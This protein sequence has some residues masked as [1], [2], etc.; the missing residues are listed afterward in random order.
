MFTFL[1]CSA[2]A[3]QYSEARE[4]LGKATQIEEE[5]L[6]S[7]PERMVEL[8]F[9]SAFIT[10]EVNS[11]LILRDNLGVSKRYFMGRVEI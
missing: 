11:L 2:Q 1:L 4:L 6:G 7:R 9:L 3:G 5:E 10:D 8:T